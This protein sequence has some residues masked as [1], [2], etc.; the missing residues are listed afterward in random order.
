MGRRK[1]ISPLEGHEEWI[2]SHTRIEIMERFQVTYDYV[3]NF[4]IKK[5]IKPVNMR[6]RSKF[7]PDDE[8][9]EYAK[10]HTI[11]DIAQKYNRCY[12]SIVTICH[13]YNITPAKNKPK[14]AKPC[15]A[16]LLRKTGEAHDMI[17]ELSKTFTDASIARVFGYSKERIRQ[18]RNEEN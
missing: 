17:R 13:R 11:R 14:E 8:F 4:C 10:T 6:K 5:G 18:I 9:I 15:K 3:N 1:Q 7:V 2:Q 16:I 12:G